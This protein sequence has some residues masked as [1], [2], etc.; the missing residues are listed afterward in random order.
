MNGRVVLRPISLAHIQVQ[1]TAANQDKS[2]LAEG[3]KN[4]NI[5]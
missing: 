4:I 2:S 5:T 1:N 3:T